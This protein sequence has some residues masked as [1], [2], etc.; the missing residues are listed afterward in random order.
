VAHF[1]KNLKRNGSE[2]KNNNIQSKIYIKAAF[3]KFFMKIFGLNINLRK[4]KLLLL[5]EIR[6]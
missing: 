4:A 1:C 6:W 3:A 5:Y 2:K